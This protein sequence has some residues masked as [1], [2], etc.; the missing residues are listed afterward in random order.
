MSPSD[1]HCQVQ[2]VAALT[3]RLAGGEA[4]RQVLQARLQE[5]DALALLQAS[6]LGAQ[7]KTRPASSKVFLTLQSA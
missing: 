5:A 2:G 3:E 4:E 7:D 6:A 1:G